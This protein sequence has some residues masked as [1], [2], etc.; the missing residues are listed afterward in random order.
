MSTWCLVLHSLYNAQTWYF[1]VE[2]TSTFLT[3]TAYQEAHLHIQNFNNNK[4]SIQPC[5]ESDGRLRANLNM[6][7][8]CYTFGCFKRYQANRI[9]NLVM[10]SSNSQ[11]NFLTHR[12][13]SRIEAS[14]HN[15]LSNSPWLVCADMAGRLCQTKCPPSQF[16]CCHNPEFQK[17]S[18]VVVD[19]ELKLIIE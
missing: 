8:A 19:C 1:Q 12:Q 18:G 7:V 10:C 3:S 17:C 5:E 11:F 2:T 15:N 16:C 14:R 9:S 13:K 6:F 4:L